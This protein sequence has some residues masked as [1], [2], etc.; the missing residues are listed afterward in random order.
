MTR[1]TKWPNGHPLKVPYRLQHIRRYEEKAVGSNAYRRRMVE[2][3][4]KFSVSPN[5]IAHYW[6]LLATADARELTPKTCCRYCWGQDN[7]YQFTKNEALRARREHLKRQLALPEDA[8]VP[9]DEEGGDDFDRTKDPNSECPECRG[10]GTFDLGALDFA[11]MS[12]A[13]ALLYDGVRIGSDGSVEV[14]MR[15]RTQAMQMLQRLLGFEVERK[16]MLLRTFDPAQLH[17]DELVREIERLQ[18]DVSTPP[19]MPG[20]SNMRAA[21]PSIVDE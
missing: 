6:W 10:A 5:Q 17:D 15:N 12:P 21:D 14:K 20:P 3:A 8:R 13:A 9:F 4:K 7:Q 11:K 18:Q 1:R 16:M 19:E 2:L